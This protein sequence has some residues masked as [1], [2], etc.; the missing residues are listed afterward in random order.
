MIPK[1]EFPRPDRERASWLNLNGE[2]E[3]KLLPHGKGE[4]TPEGFD[5]KITVPYS[6]VCP[7]SGVEEDV[8]GV[9][10]YRRTVS[11]KKKGRLFLCFGGVDYIADVY[12]NGQFAA[13]HQGG[14]N[15]FDIDVS[16]FWR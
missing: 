5:R 11:F 1:H 10:W 9:G 15:E 12:V 8:P 14:Y 16:D 6:W 4:D 13:R 3:F 7:L 2:W